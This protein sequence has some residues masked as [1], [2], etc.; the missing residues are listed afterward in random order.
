M[1]VSEKEMKG[2]FWSKLKKS[3]KRAGMKV[4][5]KALQLYYAL[6]SPNTPAW[7]KA[8]IIGALSYFISP[9]DLF[10]DIILSTI[11]TISTMM[12]RRMRVS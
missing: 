3:A 8:V 1:N 4:V 11:K 5:Y 12:V 9:I 2:A 7:A 10:P 6:K